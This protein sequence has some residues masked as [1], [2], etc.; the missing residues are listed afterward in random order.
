METSLKT[1]LKNHNFAMLLLT[2]KSNAAFP[3]K[4]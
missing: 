2:F 4:L 3:K 1:L